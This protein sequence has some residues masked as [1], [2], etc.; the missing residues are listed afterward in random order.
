HHWPAGAA[1]RV[2]MGLHTG[3][4]RRTVEGY[5]GMDLHRGARICHAAHGGQALLSH[6]TAALVETDLPDGVSLRDAGSHRL[7]DLAHP[8]HLFDLVVPGLPADFPPLRTLDAHPNN[9]P[10][11]LTPLIG[12]EPQLAAARRL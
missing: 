9:L 11:Q 3:Q 6:A 4:P 7:K 12:R 8:E 5:A 2:R 1:P 10:A